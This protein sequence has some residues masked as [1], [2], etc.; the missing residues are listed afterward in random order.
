[1]N[2]WSY[3]LT[4]VGVTA[5]YL[6]GKGKAVGWLIGL[7]AQ[8]LW[9]GYGIATHQYGF[10]LSAV[11]YGYVYTRNA[12]QWLSLEIDSIQWGD[13]EGDLL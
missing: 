3:I 1:M 13:L 11:A 2:Y 12:L 6:A 4:A 8:L 5:L 9:I 7:L 10:I